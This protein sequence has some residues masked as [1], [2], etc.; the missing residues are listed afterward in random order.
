MMSDKKRCNEGVKCIMRCPECD[1]PAITGKFI[2]NLDF[3][4]GAGGGKGNV[5]PQLRVHNHIET[6]KLQCESCD[7]EID[8]YPT[9][10]AMDSVIKPKLQ[11]MLNFASSH[12]LLHRTTFVDLGKDGPD[13]FSYDD[14]E[15]VMVCE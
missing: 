9:L 11:R 5:S 2:S 15:Y 13:A 3:G 12:F 6:L 8:E 14:Q 10:D 1:S 4:Y 7:W